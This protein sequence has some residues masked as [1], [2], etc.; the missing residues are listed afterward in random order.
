MVAFDAVHP[1]VVLRSA[2]ADRSWRARD[3][4]RGTRS[5][6]RVAVS[7]DE[8]VANTE[9]KSTIDVFD[10]EKMPP[11]TL[12]SVWG[13][14]TPRHVYRLVPCVLTSGKAMWADPSPLRR[15]NFFREGTSGG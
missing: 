9:P 7:R 4:G 15:H 14:V 13:K 5:A 3:S 6:G 8:P 1:R 12:G 2:R 11:V 10:L